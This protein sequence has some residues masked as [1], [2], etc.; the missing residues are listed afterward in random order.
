MVSR[1]TIKADRFDAA[2]GDVGLVADLAGS[3]I[4]PAGSLTL[5]TGATL[6]L[7]IT[8]LGLKAG[9]GDFAVNGSTGDVSIS[10]GKLAID[11]S[12]GN[13]SMEDGKQLQVH[14]VERIQKVVVPHTDFT[15]AATTDFTDYEID[16]VYDFVVTGVFVR[17]DVDFT[18]GSVSA[19]EMTVGDAVSAVGYVP[20]GRF[21]L[22]SN[23]PGTLDGDAAA[24]R[25]GYTA[26]YGVVK[27]QT[28]T[29][30]IVRVTLNTTGDNCSALNT[31]SVDMYVRYFTLPS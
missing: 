23:T 6:T 2:T 27:F 26:T 3:T 17:Y 9:G 28:G 31:G 14:G 1:R 20:A 18:G 13:L 15:A 30:N 24:D 22:F 21:A 29:N 10:S 19:V 12:L 8:A 25:G 16:T 5:K 11:S 7:G 4:T